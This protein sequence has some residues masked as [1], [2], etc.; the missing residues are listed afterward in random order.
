MSVPQ[1]KLELQRERRK[2]ATRVSILSASEALFTERGYEHTS[3]DDIASAAGVAKRTVYLHFPSKAA[4]MLAYFDGWLD[5][6][7]EL[8]QHRPVDEDIA[9]SVR[10][11]SIGMV[12]NGWIDAAEGGGQTNP[13]VTQ[14]FTGPPE[15]AGHIFQSWVRAQDS[16]A[17]DY[18]LRGAAVD[19]P[20]APRARALSVY[21]IWHSSMVAA[22]NPL[23]T[24]HA[25]TGAAGVDVFTTLT[26]GKM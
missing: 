13:F 15:I 7:V 20:N 19:N 25:R 2:L 16:L 9:V 24:E 11:A 3:V 10:E 1:S 6:F 18:A 22:R 17:A 21:L 26:S 4:I 14:V 5:A 8:L 23:A 12:Q